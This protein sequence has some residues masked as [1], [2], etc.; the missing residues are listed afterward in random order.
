MSHLYYTTKS[1]KGQHLNYE[2]RKKI[3]L[4][5]FHS[6]IYFGNLQSKFIP[7]SSKIRPLTN[8]LLCD[9]IMLNHSR[10]RFESIGTDTNKTDKEEAMKDKYD[11]IKHLT[12]PQYDDFPPM[13]INDRAAQFSPF[14]ALVGY[15]DAVS[16]TARLTDS[17]RVL[18]DDKEK[19][20]NESLNSII[21]SLDS[22][23]IVAV[24]Y[25]V[26]DEKKSGGR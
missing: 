18:T 2:E 10:Q 21:D 12:R 9:I 5:K 7:A 4:S 26:P 8:R 16:E 17:R 3:E 1:K 13:S 23:P 20:L 14:A 22:Q 11:N 25:F 24:T 19:Q 15:D 6:G